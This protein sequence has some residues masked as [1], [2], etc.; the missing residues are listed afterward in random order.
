MLS[1]LVSPAPTILPVTARWQSDRILIRG[2]ENIRQVEFSSVSAYPLPGEL[3]LGLPEGWQGEF[4]DA[5]SGGDLRVDR[6]P[7]PEVK[8]GEPIKLSLSF[9]IP[10]SERRSFATVNLRLSGEYVMDFP[11]PVLL[12][13]E[14]E[15]QI[16]QQVLD[17]KE[18]F[19]VQNQALQFHILKQQSGNLIR[20]QDHLTRTYLVDNFP[21]VI[22][23]FFL[24]YHIGGLQPLIFTTDAEQAFTQLESV[25]AEVASDG[26]WRGVRVS[27]T[28]QHQPEL[29]G[30][31]FAIDYL[32]LP[33]SEIVRIVLR[34][35]NPTPRHIRWVGGFFIN[36]AFQGVMDEIVIQAPGG[37]RIWERNHVLKP[38]T[39]LANLRQPWAV[40]KKDDQSLILAAMPQVKGKSV[41]GSVMVFDFNQLLGGLLVS[42]SQTGP[43]G[44]KA[45]EFALATGKNGQSA[46]ELIEALNN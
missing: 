1:E 27:W 46:S 2:Q 33:G 3:S 28:M 44:D 25:Q 17:G 43:H 5:K 23:H 15:A 10:A 42:I 39:S 34:H 30:Q 11:L 26:H 35:H 16:T 45:L 18:I 38:F 6:I 21:K 12:K 31:D 14:G 24:P 22:P 13:T 41:Q 19:T 4:L 20:L 36:V 7:M 29:K 32:V 40:F 8:P 37:T 9:T